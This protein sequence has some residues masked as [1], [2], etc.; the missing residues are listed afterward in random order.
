M[1]VPSEYQRATDDFYKFLEDAR[2]VA[3]FTTT[4]QAYTMAQGV[5]QVFRRR[6]EVSEAIRF[7]SVLPVGLRALFVADRDISESKRSFEDRGHMTKEARS[8]RPLHNFSPESAIRDVA[9]AL[10]R[11]IDQAALDGVLKTISEGAVQ[12]WQV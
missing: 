4:N 9:I 11:N 8:L 6:L 2:D 10:R 3:G 7:L 1:P 5:L 12:F